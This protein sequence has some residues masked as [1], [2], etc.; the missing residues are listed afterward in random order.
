[1]IFVCQK[2]EEIE[3]NRNLCPDQ[4]SNRATSLYES[5][6]LLLQCAARWECAILCV[7]LRVA[8]L[9]NS[10]RLTFILTAVRTTFVYTER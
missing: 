8:T 5:G 2:A 6:T 10:K 4:D 3:Q 7:F 1:L 9:L